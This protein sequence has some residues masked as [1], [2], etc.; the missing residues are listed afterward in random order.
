MQ[1]LTPSKVPRPTDR[2]VLSDLLLVG[3]V[4]LI[5][6]YRQS[7]KSMAACSI[8][9][10]V[11]TGSNWG[12]HVH[13][14]PDGPNDVIYLTAQSAGHVS[15]QIVDNGYYV[16]PGRP[17]FSNV[18]VAQIT[19]DL[20][21]ERSNSP[22]Q[23]SV[24]PAFETL[25]AT[26]KEMT[27]GQKASV[28][29]IDDLPLMFASCRLSFDSDAHKLY[30]KL[31]Q[32]AAE[33][34]HSLLIVAPASFK[35]PAGSSV[36][37]EGHSDLIFRCERFI[38]EQQQMAANVRLD[39]TFSPIQNRRGKLAQPTNLSLR[40]MPVVGLEITPMA[41]ETVVPVKLS[42][43]PRHLDTI[44]TLLKDISTTP[45][46]E[47]VIL[48]YSGGRPLPKATITSVL[49]HL[50]ELTGDT[51]TAPDIRANVHLLCYRHRTALKALV[52]QDRTIIANQEELNGDSH[53]EQHSDF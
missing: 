3:G 27:D 53:D 51:S 38:S 43:S 42:I 4:T 5:T 7:F 46:N 28:L 6:G 47:R 2:A 13:G 8:A 14:R 31:R 12:D 26:L 23:I 25:R 24:A 34:A 48:R 39:A 15:Q 19:A 1:F 33:V 30:R 20:F 18:K 49:K 45:L 41:R 22:E 9:A 37:L 35:G 50:Q 21:A 29:I 52:K 36:A 16:A 44:D 32:L 17:E 40:E 10:S 11:S